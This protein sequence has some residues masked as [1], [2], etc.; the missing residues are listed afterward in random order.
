MSSPSGR[1]RRAAV[2]PKG[3]PHD[4]LPIPP[5][6][7][8]PGGQDKN[9][10]LERLRPE[11]EASGLAWDVENGGAHLKLKIEGRLAGVLPRAGASSEGGRAFKNVRA[12]ARRLIRELAP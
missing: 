3:K 2:V 4:G 8:T 6:P 1:R 10:A 5:P 9:R 7:S 12:Q 11:L